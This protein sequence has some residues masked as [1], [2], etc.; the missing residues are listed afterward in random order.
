[1]KVKILAL[2]VV[3]AMSLSLLMTACGAPSAE[4]SNTS[5]IQ[6]TSQGS[7]QNTT[8]QSNTGSASQEPK[9]GGT[10]KVTINS[11]PGSL[12]MHL[13]DSERAQIPGCHVFETLLAQDTKGNPH[14][15]LCTYEVKENGLVIELKMREN[16]KFH[17][18]DIMDIDDVMASINR[19]LKNVSFAKKA[20][21]EKL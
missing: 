2:L 19:W 13:E 10:L 6:S 8:T 16:V 12:D 7:T 3:A 17:N 15:L 1:M 5:S 14:P 11:D 21:G 9:R 20:V 18:G 4:K